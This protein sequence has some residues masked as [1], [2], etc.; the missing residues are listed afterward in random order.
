MAQDGARG[1]EVSQEQIAPRDHGDSLPQP[2][3]RSGTVSL[4][5]LDTAG[6]GAQ[7]NGVRDYANLVPLPPDPGGYTIKVKSHG[8]ALH[9]N[10]PLSPSIPFDTDQGMESHSESRKEQGGNSGAVQAAPAVAAA[11]TQGSG[12][13]TISG[14]SRPDT[15]STSWRRAGKQPVE[16]ERT[17][18][19]RAPIIVDLGKARGLA[20]ARL[21]MLRGTVESLQLA[22]RHFVLDFSLEGDFEHV[23]RSGPWRYHGGDAVLIRDL[24]EGEDPNM[25][26]FDSMPIWVQFTRIPF[27][28]LSKQLA[29]DLGKKLSE[30]IY[31]DNDARGDICEKFI[32][33]CVR[34]PI[35]RALQRWITLQDEFSNEEVV[36]TVLY[37]RLPT[38]CLCC[39]VIS[40]KG[41]ECDLPEMLRRRR[42]SLALGVPSTPV[43]D[44]R[45]W[46]LPVTAGEVGRALQMDTPW[47]NVAA[48]GAWR[49]PTTTVL[50]IVANVVK[51]V[52]KLFVHDKAAEHVM[53]EV[54]S[55]ANKDNDKVEPTAP[56]TAT[57][58]ESKI[59][60]KIV[61]NLSTMNTTDTKH[62]TVAD[63]SIDADVIRLAAIPLARLDAPDAANVSDKLVNNNQ[64]KAT[65]STDTKTDA[66]GRRLWKRK[67][68]EELGEAKPSLALDNTDTTRLKAKMGDA[69]LAPAE[70]GGRCWA[71]EEDRTLWQPT[72]KRQS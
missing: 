18:D 32:R 19:E 28:L 1:N 54:I 70:G 50:A 34:F 38:F 31:I 26:R 33:V 48:F 43:K 20:R 6:D 37:E 10:I 35:A 57:S 47:R 9:Q 61:T 21:V 7:G 30:C 22:D 14:S 27:Y 24:K 36:V 60:D 58:G 52:E 44:P 53:A 72:T 63:T 15:A 55:G 11:A 69:P 62:Y 17:E 16:D 68:R 66:A 42:Y 67:T 2:T 49:D 40:H 3:A 23:T 5:E 46:Y 12:P 8:A 56:P 25:V 59:D 64:T 29:R 65:D 13:I 45:K 71:S 39:G 51:E 41:E 4:P